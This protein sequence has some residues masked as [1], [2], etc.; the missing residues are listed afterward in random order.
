M[1]LSRE[2]SVQGESISG[3]YAG[4]EPAII[5]VKTLPQHVSSALDA[6]RWQQGLSDGGDGRDG[7]GTGDG[8]LRID[9]A[10]DLAGDVANVFD[11]EVGS[12]P[13]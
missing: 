4:L 9:L 10:G 11:C 3:E 7:K 13:T 12:K 2:K 8:Q 6:K 5:T 1:G